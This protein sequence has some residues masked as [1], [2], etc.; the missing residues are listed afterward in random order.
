MEAKNDPFGGVLVAPSAI[1]ADVGQFRAALE[2][3]LDKWEREG[4]R[5]VW[6]TV[7]AGLCASHTADLFARGFAVHHVA[8]RSGDLV[9]TKWL[10]KEERNML[11]IGPSFYVGIG[12]L[13]IDSEGKMLVVRERYVT[14]KLWKLPGGLVSPG[15]DL[16]AAAVREV[17]EETGVEAVFE[18]L[19]CVRYLPHARYGFSDL[20]FVARLRLK[21]DDATGH[22]LHRQEEEIAEVCWMKPEEY[23][24]HP[25]TPRMMKE[26]VLFAMGNKGVEPMVMPAFNNKNNKQYLY[27]FGGKPLHQ[28]LS[29]KL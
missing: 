17:R 21:H 1:P 16:G 5:G 27:N 12:G 11:P 2:I 24:K 3:A 14:G 23:L 28:M 15:E 8:P 7:P 4:K 9:L 29:P 13:V 6:I 26:V 19:L 10:P 25:K 22:E 18:S 20:Y